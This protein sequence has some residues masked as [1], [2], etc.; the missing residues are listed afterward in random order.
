MIND[1]TAATVALR[2][3]AH[4]GPKTFQML[5]MQFGP[6]EELFDRR[7]E[8]LA[9]LPRLNMEKA[10]RI[11]ESGDAMDSVR[12]RLEE[13]A[14]HGITAVTFFD[15]EYPESLRQISDPPP[16]FYLRGGL[17]D[18]SR[19]VAVVGSHKASSEGIGDAVAIGKRLAE[20]GVAVVSGLARGVDAGA[21]VGAIAG[22][23]KT[24]A[25]LGCG[26]EN[27]YPR[28]NKPLAEQ[29]ALHGGLLSEYPVNAKSAV[30]QLLARNRVVVGLA[31]AVVVVELLEKSKGTMSA[32]ELA[33]KQGKPVFVLARETSKAVQELVGQ[34]AYV[35]DEPSSLDAVMAYV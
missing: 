1:R 12:N 10:A 14:M 15:E 19:S 34:G 25:A 7:P 33:F 26:I 32:A 31:Q 29:V 5:V 9:D 21:H 24:Y 3:V 30:P 6:P 28:E 20:E 23:G 35:I 22:A 2:E 16:F 18:A 11:L 13:L 8:E 17:P 27:I 4:V